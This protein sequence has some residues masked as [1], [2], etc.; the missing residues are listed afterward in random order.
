M[1]HL[2]SLRTFQLSFD[3]YKRFILI[4][5]VITFFLVFGKTSIPIASM[6]IAM[7]IF[8]CLFFGVIFIAF[9][10]PALRK[11]LIYYKNFGL[12]KTCIILNSLLIDF[13]IS[14]IIIYLSKTF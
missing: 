6:I 2:F 9:R 5:L 11:Q 14:V 10:A 12:S 1:K 13:L 8:K 3:F 4:S 7:L